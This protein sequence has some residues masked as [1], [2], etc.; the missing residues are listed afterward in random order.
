MSFMSYEEILDAIKNG[1]IRIAYYAIKDS[2]D[3]TMK[4]DKEEFVDL[5]VSPTGNKKAIEIAEYFK[6]SC[7]DDSVYFHV[8]P[9]AKIEITS[10]ID[11][12]KFLTFETN[13]N[14]IHSIEK[15]NEFKVYPQQSIVVETSEYIELSDKIG[16]SIY[17][18]VSKTNLGFSHI[19]TIIDPRWKGVLQIGIAN[20]SRYPQHLDYLDEFCT[21]RFHRLDDI[22][23]KPPRPENR[24]Y[25]ERNWWKTGQVSLPL[26]KRNLGN[27]T[28]WEKIINEKTIEY[29]KKFFQYLVIG[30]GAIVFLFFLTKLINGLQDLEYIKTKS[31]DNSNKVVELNKDVENLDNQILISGSREINFPSTNTGISIELNEPLNT[32]PMVFLEFDNLPREQIKYTISYPQIGSIKAPQYS[33]VVIDYSYSGNQVLKGHMRYLIV[34]R[35][36]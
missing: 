25:F 1:E 6:R 5:A 31:D 8:G 28:L 12:R 21:V 17:A 22:S 14:P 3:Q 15:S 7:K 34:Y 9:N 4:F 18:T 33:N 16:A 32:P 36:P 30:G 13:S 10:W 26:G 20:L 19:S 24:A 35:K 11:N 29:I 23:K 27:T 2:L